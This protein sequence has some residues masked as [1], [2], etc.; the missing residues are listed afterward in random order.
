MVFFVDTLR[1]LSK[2][3]LYVYKFRLMK[4]KCTITLSRENVKSYGSKL[5]KFE[6]KTMKEIPKDIKNSPQ[7]KPIFTYL[8]K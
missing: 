4:I 5:V 7:I 6:L 8:T 3:V 1:Y 2:V